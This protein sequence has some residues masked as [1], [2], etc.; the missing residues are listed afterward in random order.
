METLLDT[1]DTHF[2]ALLVRKLKTQQLETELSGDV[3]PPWAVEPCKYHGH[4][5]L[6]L[7]CYKRSA[8]VCLVGWSIGSWL[9]RGVCLRMGRGG[10]ISRSSVD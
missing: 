8:G 3:V 1:G 7:Q 10:E 4:V 2:L 5:A 9:M 6:G